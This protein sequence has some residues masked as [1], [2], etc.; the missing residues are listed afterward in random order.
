MLEKIFLSKS[1]RPSA[2]IFGM[3]EYHQLV[4]VQNKSLGP[5]VAPQWAPRVICIGLFTAN[6]KHINVLQ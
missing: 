6:I 5:K 2:L 4:F 3:Y 1:T